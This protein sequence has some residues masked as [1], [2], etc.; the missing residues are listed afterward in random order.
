MNTRKSLY[1]IDEFYKKGA[2]LYASYE[3][4]RYRIA[5]EE[6]QLKLSIWPEPYGYEATSKELIKDYFL[7][8]TEQGLD[9]CYDILCRES[10]GFGG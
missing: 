4:M 1:E 2:V 9:E 8:A 7:E 10:A 3:G 6:E 5:L